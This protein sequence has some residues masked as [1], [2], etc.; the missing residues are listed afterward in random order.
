M[1]EPRLPC[2]TCGREALAETIERND[3]L[4]QACRNEAR[5]PDGLSEIQERF[6]FLGSFV[7]W[8]VVSCYVVYRCRLA[9]WN[10][11]WAIFIVIWLAPV[12]H[13][14]TTVVFGAIAWIWRCFQGGE[15]R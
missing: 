14:G 8:I 4:C 11:F 5:D 3:G 9:D 13:L 2:S 7:G 12:F 1:T 15:E 10:W 6:L